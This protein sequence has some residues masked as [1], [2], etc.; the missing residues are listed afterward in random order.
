MMHYMERNHQEF[1]QFHL[2]HLVIY[3]PDDQR[4]SFRIYSV[5]AKI[6]VTL[7]RSLFKETFPLVESTW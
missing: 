1:H 5:D 4:I 7:W 6:L 3:K 2:L